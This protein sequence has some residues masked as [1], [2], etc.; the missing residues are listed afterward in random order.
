VFGKRALE[1]ALNIVVAENA[2]LKQR[3]RDVEAEKALLLDRIMA[4]TNP[5]ALREVHRPLPKGSE[6]LPEEPE[7][8]KHKRHR[9]P[10]NDLMAPPTRPA[11]P[12]NPFPSPTVNPPPANPEKVS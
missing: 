4:L 5:G 9:Y 10:G 2:D 3:V 1:K 7:E 11:T 8:Q 12:P 6:V